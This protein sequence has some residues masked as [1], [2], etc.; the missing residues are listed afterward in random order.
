MKADRVFRALANKHRLGILFW[1]QN[2]RG[3]FRPQIAGDLVRDGVCG[4]LIAKKLRVSH[5]TAS[6]HLKILSQ[7]GLIRGKRIKQWTFYKRDESTIRK[8]KKTVF[9][10]V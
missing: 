10:N 3:H 6:E 2:P 9:P 1:L 7:A 5:P 4:C 8:I